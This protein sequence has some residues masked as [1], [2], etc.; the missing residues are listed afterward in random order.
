MRAF[1]LIAAL[2]MFYSHRCTAVHRMGMYHFYCLSISPKK[3]HL[4][5]AICVAPAHSPVG[6]LGDEARRRQQPARGHRE[7][8]R[9]L[10]GRFL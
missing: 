10:E 9:D 8:F 6:V 4:P 1:N 7:T 5:Q 3:G 2:Y